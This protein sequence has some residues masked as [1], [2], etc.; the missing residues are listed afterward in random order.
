LHVLVSYYLKEWFLERKL[1]NP[2]SRER[3]NKYPNSRERRDK[4]MSFMCN[5]SFDG[6]FGFQKLTLEAACLFGLWQSTGFGPKAAGFRAGGGRSV[7][8]L[9]SLGFRDLNWVNGGGGFHSHPVGAHEA[10]TKA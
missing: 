1:S 5:V 10:E 9:A 2:N 7:F 6:L 8:A 4:F 3:R